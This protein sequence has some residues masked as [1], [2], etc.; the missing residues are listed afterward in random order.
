MIM[1]NFEIGILDF[2]QKVF[3]NPFF[4][5]VLPYITRLADDLKYFIALAVVFMIFKKT[6][7]IGLTLLLSLFIGYFV[8]NLFI[9]NAVARIRPYDVNTLADV[10]IHKPSSYSFPSGHSLMAAELATSVFIFNKKLLG[11]AAIVFAA[12]IAFSRLY[13]YVHYPTDVLG[14]AALG[15]LIA[16]LSSLIVKAVYKRIEGKRI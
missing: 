7:K 6:R 4:D 9:K 16:F 13:L 2:I 1:N 15:V 11:W 3:K 8:G 5:F 14:G 12:A 10:I